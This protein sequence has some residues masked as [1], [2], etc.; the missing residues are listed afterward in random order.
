MVWREVD[1]IVFISGNRL[2]FSLAII[3]AWPPREE[4]ISYEVRLYPVFG[5]SETD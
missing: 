5:T 3:A 4:G 2:L 1:C